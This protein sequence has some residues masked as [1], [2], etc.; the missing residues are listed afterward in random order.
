MS[1]ISQAIPI[2]TGHPGS[3]PPDVRS[4]FEVKEA[5]IVDDDDCLIDDDYDN[6][7]AILVEKLK[8]ILREVLTPNLKWKIRIKDLPGLQDSSTSRST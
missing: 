4:D 5:D 8:G 2:D 7:N 6:K 3:E 1:L